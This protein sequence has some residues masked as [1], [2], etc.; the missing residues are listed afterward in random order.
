MTLNKFLTLMCVAVLLAA[1]ASN[2][3]KPETDPVDTTPVE[4][5]DDRNVQT[6]PW[7]G[8]PAYDPAQL[9]NPDSLLSQRV[10]YFDFD[11]AEV[12]SEYRNIVREHARFMS[13]NSGY[14]MT[15]EGHADERGTREYNVA[16][17]ERRAMSVGD[18][19]RAQGASDGQIDHVS[20]GEERPVALCHEES[21]WWKNRRV[22]IVY[23]AN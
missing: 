8:K 7:D 18:L 11:R 5:P 21:C 17:G 1:C 22:E 23:T 4:T 13:Q 6:N 9:D 15:L 12:K 10:I 3:P 20:Y 14:Q 2:E 19:M 16:L